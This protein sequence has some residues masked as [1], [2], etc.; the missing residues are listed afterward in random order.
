MRH[1]DLTDSGRIP[2]REIDHRLPTRNGARTLLNLLQSQELEIIASGNTAFDEDD[3]WR[4]RIDSSGD[5]V[6]EKRESGS[7]VNKKTWT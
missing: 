3:N 1:T 4:L 7:W 2:H 5:L 6:L